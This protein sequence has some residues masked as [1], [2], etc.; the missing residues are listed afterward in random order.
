MHT[1]V[2]VAQVTLRGCVFILCS[3]CPRSINTSVFLI[4]S[5]LEIFFFFLIA[6]KNASPKKFLAV[7]SPSFSFSNETLLVPSW[8]E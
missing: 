6:H 1:R 8:E 3:A 2:S 5:I 4:M 7:R